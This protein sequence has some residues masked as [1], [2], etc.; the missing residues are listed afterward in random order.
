MR[1]LT[2]GLESWMMSR[3][4]VVEK[5]EDEDDALSILTHN[6]EFDVVVVSQVDEMFPYNLRAR[7]VSTPLIMLVKP[8]HTNTRVDLLNRGADRCLRL[9]VHKFELH[10]Y[11]NALVRRAQW[12]AGHT[13]SNI[14]TVDDISLDTINR[15]VEVLG[16]RVQFTP[17]QYQLLMCLM[18]KPTRV[19]S[20]AGIITQLYADADAPGDKLIDVMVCKI[21][22]KLAHLDYQAIGTAWGRGYKMGAKGVPTE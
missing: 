2:V 6:G 13:L 7:K 11:M 8:D 21:R 3:D 22:K 19:F 14:L 12:E 20:R 9:P 10:A 18:R 4:H 16:K 1:V 17:K 5:A 15:T